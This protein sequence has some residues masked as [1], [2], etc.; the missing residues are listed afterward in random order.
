VSFLW[1]LQ[2]L[3]VK[4]KP[5]NLGM[6]RLR[7]AD[8]RDGWHGDA[9]QPFA[10]ANLV[11]ARCSYDARRLRSRRP[12]RLID[13]SALHIWV[14]GKLEHLR[15]SP[16]QIAGR[17][18]T[19]NPDQRVSHETIY[20]AIYAQPRGGLKAAWVLHLKRSA[21]RCAGCFRPQPV[22][23]STVQPLQPPGPWP[24]APHG[25]SLAP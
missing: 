22:T 3:A 13:G 5:R 1:H 18:R 10:V 25:R 15:W 20:A 23:P 8:I 16:E 12:R 14:R 11:S 6:C 17:L 9:Q 4:A 24:A 21:P 7:T 19:M 2:G